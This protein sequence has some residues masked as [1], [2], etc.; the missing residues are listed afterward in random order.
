VCVSEAVV[1][2]PPVITDDDSSAAAET[3]ERRRR[4]KYK[5]RQFDRRA[6]KAALLPSLRN[7]DSVA[8]RH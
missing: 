4:P 7:L 8:I 6:L 2:A 5:S 3:L 1:G